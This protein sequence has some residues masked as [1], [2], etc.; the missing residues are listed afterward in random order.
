MSSR[1]A[2]M[3][4]VLRGV[5]L[6]STGGNTADVQTFFARFPDWRC[7]AFNGINLNDTTRDCLSKPFHPNMQVMMNSMSQCP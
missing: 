2:D 1:M 5:Y 4:E 6:W 3:F 7:P